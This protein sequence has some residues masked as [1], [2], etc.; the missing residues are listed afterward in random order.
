[1]T[2]DH[3]QARLQRIEDHLRSLDERVSVLSA[4]DDG[5]ARDRIRETFADNPRMVI[6]LRGIQRGMTQTAIAAALKTRSLPGAHQSLV[7][8]ALSELEELQFVKKVPGGGYVQ[9]DGWVDF[10]LE[11]TLKKTLRAKNIADLS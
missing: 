10:G 7:S 5:P 11:K 4:V 9:R 3:T 1:M 8:A 6:I 2:A